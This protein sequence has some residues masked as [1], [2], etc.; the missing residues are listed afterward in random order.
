ML[1]IKTKN[2][3]EI[4]LSPLKL[5]AFNPIAAFIVAIIFTIACF[6]R[7]YSQRSKRILTICATFWWVYSFFELDMTNW[8]SFTGDMAI[9]VDLVV[10]GPIILFF[11]IC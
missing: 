9:R 1:Y 7:F 3:M 8:R 11:G 6:L 4:L 10:L 2:N 5:F